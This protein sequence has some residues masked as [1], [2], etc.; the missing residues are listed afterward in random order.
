[1]AQSL[2]Q[3]HEQITREHDILRLV[4]GTAV[5]SLGLSV[6]YV[7]WVLRAGYLLTS[8]LSSMPA[9]QFIDPLPILNSRTLLSR[10][11]EEDDDHDRDDDSLQTLLGRTRR[12][13]AVASHP[14]ASE[15]SVQ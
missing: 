4:A 9:W 13:P 2:E 5:V 15:E 11:R 10:R 1:M 3:L 6:G 8:M 12:R 7:L 14:R